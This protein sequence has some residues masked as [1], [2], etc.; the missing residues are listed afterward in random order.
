M[1][2]IKHK[3]LNLAI[4]HLFKGFNEDDII[5]FDKQDFIY[6]GNKMSKGEVD[7]MIKTLQLLDNN[8]GY[9]YLLNE[10]EYKA[11]EALFYKSTNEEDLIFSRASLYLIASLRKR[12]NQLLE[13][14][15][16]WIQQKNIKSN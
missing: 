13:D 14:Y 9:N 5:R 7:N 4:K 10:M 11:Q 15:K 2:N 1:R 6:K 8:D 16:T 3:I 12:K